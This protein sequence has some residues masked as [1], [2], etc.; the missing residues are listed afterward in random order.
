MTFPVITPTGPPATF[1]FARAVNE[2]LRQHG[3][4][5][6]VATDVVWEHA[7]LQ[8]MVDAADATPTVGLAFPNVEGTTHRLLR[9]RATQAPRRCVALLPFHCVYIPA[10]TVA[11]VGWM[12]EAFEGYG[13]DDFDYL[14]RVLEADLDPVVYDG[15][16]VFHDDRRCVYRK[17]AD[18]DQL[19]AHNK[20]VFL[21]KWQKAP[22]EVLHELE[23][24]PPRR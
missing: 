6:L 19:F 21:Q 8:R 16:E 10:R 20:T 11:L 9:D 13:M 18:F 1:N 5:L 3:R 22:E 17:R 2:G 4:G 12:D 7:P 15:I 23:S 24:R 14:L